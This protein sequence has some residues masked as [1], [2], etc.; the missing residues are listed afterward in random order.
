MP[1]T[2][3]SSDEWGLVR[4]KQQLEYRMDIIKLAAVGEK[5]G[6]SGKAL[7]EFI[8]KETEKAEAKEKQRQEREER[9]WKREEDR[10]QRE[11]DQ[12]QRERKEKIEM[13]REPG[14]LKR[15]G[16]SKRSKRRLKMK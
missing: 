13:K 7:Q 14:Y 6:F 8:T 12:R 5:L 9:L 2:N 4:D 16:E 11:E 15:K 10:L 3:S 1:A